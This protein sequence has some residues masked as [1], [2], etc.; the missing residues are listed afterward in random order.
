MDR[1]AG[2]KGC[3]TGQMPPLSRKRMEP[4]AARMDPLHASARHQSLHHFVANAEWSDKELLQRLCQ[5][6]VREMD[7]SRGGFRHCLT[8]KNPLQN[9]LC[10][11]PIRGA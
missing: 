3:C 8:P 7:L 6:V 9:E 10:S 1:H 4:L 11:G 2:L 5:C